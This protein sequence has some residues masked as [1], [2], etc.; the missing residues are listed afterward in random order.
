M[1][2][3]Q[4]PQRKSP[5][6][7]GYDYSQAGAY[8]VTICT[9]KMVHRFGRVIRKGMVLNQVGWIALE[10]WQAIPQHSDGVEL[11]AMV[12]MPNH[13]HGILVLAGGGAILGVIVGAYKAAV[14]R[15][16]RRAG[17]VLPSEL[18]HSRYHDHIVRDERDLAR[19][20]EY[21]AHNPARWQA[22]A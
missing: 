3:Q 7:K 18:W 11:D 20:R 8:F 10:C 6:L 12:V 15:Q 16:M 5:R 19:I 13:I 21:I 22:A 14:T 9:H 1:E 2:H 4:Y 17:H